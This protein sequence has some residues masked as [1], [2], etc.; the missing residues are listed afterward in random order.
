MKKYLI[1]IKHNN[2]VYGY[3][4]AKQIEV[5]G[6]KRTLVYLND[7]LVKITVTLDM[8]DCHL[9]RKYVANEVFKIN[10]I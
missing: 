9:S 10:A 3:T 7:D 1:I 6:N 8:K 5:N 2:G 4:E